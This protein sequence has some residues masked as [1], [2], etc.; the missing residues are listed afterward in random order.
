MPY[1]LRNRKETRNFYALDDEFESKGRLI[2]STARILRNRPDTFSIS[3]WTRMVRIKLFQSRTIQ[4]AARQ[5]KVEPSIEA[6]LC[7]M[8]IPPELLNLFL[9]SEDEYPVKLQKLENFRIINKIQDQRSF[10]GFSNSHQFPNS[11]PEEVKSA[12]QFVDPDVLVSRLKFIKPEVILRRIEEFYSPS[13]EGLLTLSKDR[14]LRIRRSLSPFTIR[15]EPG[16][17]AGASAQS[18]I[19]A[20]L[21]RIYSPLSEKLFFED[22]KKG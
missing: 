3:G 6:L 17:L 18:Q 15:L 4:E 20:F 14:I 10:E 2:S 7:E 16:N 11:D 21:P 8:T 12:E 19:L 9:A 1:N 22:V 5:A 13:L